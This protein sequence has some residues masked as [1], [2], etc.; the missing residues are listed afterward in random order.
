MSIVYDL[1]LVLALLF[2]VT[3]V[4]NFALNH[5]DAI[6]RGSKF[7]WP[8]VFSLVL[9]IFFYFGWFWTHGGQTLGMK[10]W[11]MKLCSKDG[12]PVSWK[13]ALVYFL[14]AILPLGIG[15]LWSLFRQDRAALHDMIANCEMLDVR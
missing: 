13:Q 9:A 2:V 1:L 7:Y 15:F 10:T 14:A 3:A 12:K 8:Y 6:V 4:E 11:K 5:G